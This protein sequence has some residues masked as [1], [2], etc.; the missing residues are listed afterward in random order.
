MYE[1]GLLQGETSNYP[2][3]SCENEADRQTQMTED[4]IQDGAITAVACECVHPDLSNASRQQ[5]SCK[6][7]QTVGLVGMITQ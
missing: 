6:F 5:L 7:T 1:P 3:E 4:L 2:I